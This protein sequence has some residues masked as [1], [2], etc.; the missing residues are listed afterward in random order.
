MRFPDH[1][2]PAAIAFDDGFGR[3]RLQAI[4]LARKGLVPAAFPGTVCRRKNGQGVEHL[5]H[6]VPGREARR[7]SIFRN[8]QTRKV[9]WK[10][11][12]QWLTREQFHPRAHRPAVSNRRRQRSISSASGSTARTSNLVCFRNSSINLPSLTP[13]TRQ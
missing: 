6:V 3:R 7:L 1:Q 13:N 12:R 5:R 2:P 10:T 9:G 11:K 4:V 8:H